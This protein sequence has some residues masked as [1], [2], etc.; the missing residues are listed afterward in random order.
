LWTGLKYAK[1]VVQAVGAAIPGRDPFEQVGE[2]IGAAEGV[3][4]IVKAQEGNKLDKLLLILPLAKAAIKSSELLSGHELID[5]A[6]FT[7]GVT[8][9]INGEV[10]ILKAFKEPK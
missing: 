3:G 4:E 7:E 2:L 1:P 5:E 6:L 8:E 9:V 10:K